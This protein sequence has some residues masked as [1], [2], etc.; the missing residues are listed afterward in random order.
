M[1][2]PNLFLPGFPKCGTTT[3]FHWLSQ[4]PA[5]FGP[6]VKE[7]GY[8]YDSAVDGESAR[9]PRSR[10]RYTDLYRNA[11]AYPWRLD[12]STSYLSAP[13]AIERIEATCPTPRYIVSLRDPVALAWSAFRHNL[14]HRIENTDDFTEACAV[15]DDPVRGHLGVSRFCRD[16][17]SLNYRFTASVGSHLARLL[18]Q[19]ERDRVRVVLFE[20]LAGHTGSCFGSC[21]HGFPGTR[22][23]AP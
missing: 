6:A 19:A 11:T 2:L 23:I 3:L 8:F 20:D 17:L 14:Y 5:I 15:Q 10:G 4:H 16:P 21:S 18:A 9:R 12:A 7:P 13:A 1:N 22:N